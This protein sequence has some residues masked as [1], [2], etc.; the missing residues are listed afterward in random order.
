MPPDSPPAGGTSLLTVLTVVGGLLLALNLALI[1]CYLR[2][3]AAKHLFGKRAHEHATTNRALSFLGR[4]PPGSQARAIQT[5][6]EVKG[7]IPF[8]IIVSVS[9][10]GVLLLLLNIVLV[11]CFVQRRCSVSSR[12]TTDGRSLLGAVCTEIL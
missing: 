6:L 12:E 10:A 1:Y 8:I 7:E 9:V 2:R 5:V 11:S 4:P 3:R